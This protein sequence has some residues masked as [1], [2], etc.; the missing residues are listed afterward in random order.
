MSSSRIIAFAAA[1]G[2]LACSDAGREPSSSESETASFMISDA[3]NPPGRDG[4]YFLPPLVRYP[5]P[6]SGSFDTRLSPV[7][8][9]CELTS[10]PPYSCTATSRDPGL[11]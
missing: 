8:K 9:V 2:V 10:S 3:A 6:F 4:F 11:D 1:I 7:V 5:G